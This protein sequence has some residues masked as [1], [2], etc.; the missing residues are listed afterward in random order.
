M[1]SYIPTIKYSCLQGSFWMSFCIVF[2]YANLYL[3]AYGYTTSQIGIVIATAGVISTILQPLVAGL[4]DGDSKI[5][6]RG[7]ILVSS[8]IMLACA[9][10]I[11]L[12]GIRFLWYALFYGV[13]L[14]VLQILTPLVNA[15][16]MEYINRGISV[17]FG[18]ARGIGSISYAAISFVAGGLIERFSESLIPA[19]I[20]FCY[21]LVFFSAYFFRFS[22]AKHSQV[23]T[24][25]MEIADCADA[26]SSELP[27]FKQYRKF[28]IL[29]I[30]ISLIFVCHNILNNY[31]YQV[32]V[33]HNGGSTE[34]GIASGIAAALELPTM[35]AFSYMI[36]KVSS[37]TLLKISGVFFTLKAALTLMATG[38][39]GVYLAQTMQIFGFALHVP[40]SVYYTNSLIRPRDRAKG[41]AL[42][43]A[44]NTIGSIFGSLLGGFLTDGK[45][46]LFTLFVS[47]IIAAIGT[48]LMFLSTEKCEKNI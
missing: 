24:Q 1:N 37:G 3:F 43:T 25:S 7:L 44:T 46:I 31:M 21:V 38:I 13:L 39:G 36:R 11:M 28:L 6:L 42:M 16:G 20:I 10:I 30:G 27:F 26:K 18:L 29:L 19:I 9:A 23:Q 4:A 8:L 12:P 22:I 33:H 2:G 5:T 14:A 17:N 40:A 15:I 41:Q 48:L 34:M 32:M 35:I 45:G 47:T